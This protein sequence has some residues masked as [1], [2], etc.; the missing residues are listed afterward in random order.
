MH[1]TVTN[2]SGTMMHRVTRQERNIHRHNSATD[3]NRALLT[4]LSAACTTSLV[5]AITPTLPDANSKVMSSL[6]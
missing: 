2:A 1:S 3:A 5:A 6:S 4:T